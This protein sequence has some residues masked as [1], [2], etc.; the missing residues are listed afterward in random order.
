[1]QRDERIQFWVLN[2]TAFFAQLSIAMINLA[3]VYH[4]R[5]RFGLRADQIGIAASLTPLSYLIFCLVGTR[6]TE[7]FRP[8]HLVEASLLLMGLSV[9]LLVSTERVGLAFAA[10]VFF[11]ASMSLLW[12]HLMGW[13][14]RGKEEQELNRVVNAFN[15][16]WSSGVALS[17][18]I[19]GLLIEI[20]TTVA[21]VVGIG[22]FAAIFALVA[23][24]STVVVGIRAVDSEE[25][26]IRQSGTLVD[27]ST[28]LRFYAWSGIVILY[29]G[30]SIILT[31]FPLYG[32]EV[33]LISESQTGLL[34]L[35]RGLSSCLTFFILG[36]TSF[37][38][39]KRR[40]IFG[41]QG[42]FALLA[43][44][45]TQITSQLFFGLFFLLFG[46]LFSF[47][48]TQSIFHGV[49]GALQRARR[50]MVHEV[51]LTIGTVIG[52]VGG[53]AIYE[54]TSFSAVLLGCGIVAI[55]VVLLQLAGGLASAFV[56]K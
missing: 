53:G 17:S 36:R 8:R 9:T 19:G 30:M 4:L 37:W 54:H 52:A 34:L 33:L 32:R 45:A 2:I 23:I 12:P 16:S 44:W 51:L 5:I 15:V 25:A 24:A 35:L 13:L 3:L 10:L 56:R 39:F 21:F 38:H 48:Y 42:C 11:G 6:A 43:L 22:L 18:Y 49:S 1:M 7:R 20:S 27:Q 28:S 55:A 46:I 26:T 41:V 47:A 40:W 31:I 14:S 29:T 50:M